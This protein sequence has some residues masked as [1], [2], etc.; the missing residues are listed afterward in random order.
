MKQ[1][2]NI[3]YLSY[4]IFQAYE[5][6]VRTRDPAINPEMD[7]AFT[8]LRPVVDPVTPL[9]ADPTPVTPRKIATAAKKTAVRTPAPFSTKMVIIFYFIYF[10]HSSPYGDW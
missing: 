7:K 6:E 5:H 9:P 1:S 10:L 4:H 8:A 2:T 3:H